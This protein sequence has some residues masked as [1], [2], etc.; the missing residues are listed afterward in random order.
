M[1][2][3]VGSE[4]TASVINSNGSGESDDDGRTT[5]KC[6]SSSGKGG[7]HGKARWRGGSAVT[8]H[9]PI[10]VLVLTETHTDVS[11]PPPFIVHR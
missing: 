6:C 3:W 11:L 2:R 4:A 9:L 8:S 5:G 7:E 10:A 1:E